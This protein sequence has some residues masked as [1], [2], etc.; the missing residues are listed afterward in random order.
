MTTKSPT[1]L[2]GLDHSTRD[3][4]DPPDFS[5]TRLTRSADDHVTKTTYEFARAART[6]SSAE[7]SDQS[8]TGRLSASIR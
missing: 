7:A 8:E 1:A 4:A 3:R 5:G 6:D 2:A